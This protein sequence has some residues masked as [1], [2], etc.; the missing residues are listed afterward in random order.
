[1]PPPL[2]AGD[3]YPG[4]CPWPDGGH[5]PDCDW[6]THVANV[7]PPVRFNNDGAPPSPTMVVVSNTGRPER[8]LTPDEVAELRRAGRPPERHHPTDPEPE[9]DGG[10]GNPAGG[11]DR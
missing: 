11:R 9:P 7:N 10:K 3:D 8:V 2:A 4:D 5:T 1:M 6:R